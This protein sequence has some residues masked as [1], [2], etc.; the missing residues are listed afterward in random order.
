MS[1]SFSGEPGLVSVAA[2]ATTSVVTNGATGPP[3]LGIKEEPTI[4]T[5]T[6]AQPHSSRQVAFQIHLYPPLVIVVVPLEILLSVGGVG[7]ILGA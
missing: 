2:S 6:S 7:W 4:G 5:P 1:L 3:V